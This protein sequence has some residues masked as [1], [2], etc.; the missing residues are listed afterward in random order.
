MGG[1]SGTRMKESM[2]TGGMG[3]LVERDWL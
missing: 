1:R 3:D 2:K